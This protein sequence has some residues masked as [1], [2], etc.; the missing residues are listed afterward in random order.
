MA[1]RVEALPHGLMDILF[2][3]LIVVLGI[4]SLRF[5][6]WKPQ[7]K[8]IPVLLYHNI[9]DEL[10][11]DSDRK[12]MNISIL[13]FRKQLR[14][15][16]EQGYRS[17]TFKS[18]V[19]QEGLP[20]KPVIITFDDGYKGCIDNAMQILNEFGFKGILFV[21]ANLFNN[22]TKIKGLLFDVMNNDAL[23]WWSRD[24]NEVGSHGLQHKNF[25]NLKKEEKI[26]ELKDSRK[27]LE[28]IIQESVVSFSFPY[29]RFTEEDIDL[30]LEA[31][32]RFVC[33]IKRKIADY[34]LTNPVP[35]VY[36]R[37]DDT[38]LD[39]YFNITRGASRV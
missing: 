37:G 14:F 1:K 31:G 36:I 29:G 6:W 17:I 38:M 32:Y 18:V 19:Y 8:G 33:I 11:S 39:F 26:K 34:T 9:T 20:S 4:F 10:Y 25:L 22:K 12:K 24:G 5:S 21:P 28:D 2:I 23:V 15:L 35:R 16:Q 27:I 3:V 7:R 13:Q 30:A